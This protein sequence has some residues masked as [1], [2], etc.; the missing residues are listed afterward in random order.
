MHPM[1]WDAFGLPAEQHAKK[2]GTPPRTTTEKN[3]DNF[4]RQLKMLGFSYDWDR[5]LATTDVDYFRWTQWIFLVLFDT[6]FDAAAAARPADRRVADPRRGRRA[7]ARRPSRRYRDE[8]R[9]AYQIEAPVNWCPAL[10]T[11][12][13]NEEVIGGLSERGGHPVVRMPLRQWM[14]RITAYADRLEKDLDGLDW[15]ESIKTLQRNW[16]GRSTGAEVDFFIGTTRRARTASRA[17]TEFEAWRDG[18]SANGRLSAQARR[19]RA[20]DLHHA[21]RHALR[22]HLH[23]HRAGAS[24]RRAADARRSRPRRCEAYCEQGRRA[25]AISTAPTWP[26]TRRAS[27][28]APTR[29]IRSTAQPIPIWVADYVLI[30]YGTGAI[31]AVPAHD[32]RDFEFAKTVRAAD[33]AGGRSRA[34]RS[35]ARRCASAGARPAAR[36]LHRRR[37]ARSTRGRYDGLP[38]AE[39]KQRIAADLATQGPRPRGGELQAPR[40][41]L[42]PAAF[43]GRAVPDPPRAGRRRPAQRPAARRAGRMTCRSTCRR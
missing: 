1:G 41:A 33:R 37:H 39:F 8:H 9:L 14:L 43:L 26:R 17:P 2:T 29:S 42:Q 13:A 24:V 27:S 34:T 3:I 16:I 19:R 18:R 5:E 21:A 22:R 25:R 23:G 4:R 20:A 11:V 6:W 28:P 12:L 10:G 40:L 38:T 32:E 31:M 30:S 36:R 7:R 15:S 35:C